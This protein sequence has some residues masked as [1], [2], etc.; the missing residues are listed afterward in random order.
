MEVKSISIQEWQEFIE[1]LPN[2]SFFQLP[3]WAQVHEKVYMGRKEIAT[4]LFTFED[5]VQVLLPLVRTKYKFGFKT[6]ESLPWS[7]YGGF[8]YDK[9]PNQVQVRQILE[10]IISKK[11]LLLQICPSPW[12]SQNRELLQNSGLEKRPV[13]AKVMDLSAGYQWIWEN[14]IKHNCR[15]GV[16][17][18]IKSGVTM[19]PITDVTQI[20]DYYRIYLDSAQRWGLPGKKRIPLVYFESLFQTGGDR[21]KFYLMKYKN[22]FISGGIVSYDSNSCAY[23]HEVFLKEY[24]SYCPNNLLRSRLIE[25]ACNRNC[26]YFNFGTSEGVAPGVRASKEYWGTEELNYAQYVYESPL[27]KLYYKMKRLAL[28]IKKPE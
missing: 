10:H 3:I 13:T 24:G 4:K 20:K 18:A 23:L 21:V 5:N 1:K 8:I 19:T 7:W 22:K 11:V 25:N 28:F 17:K 9:K 2:Y 12:D 6:L 15:K 27:F 16:R 26:R 14:R